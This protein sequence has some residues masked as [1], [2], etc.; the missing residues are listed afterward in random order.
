[1]HNFEF[2]V[3]KWFHIYFNGFLQIELYLGT[4]TCIEIFQT[5]V[6]FYFNLKLKF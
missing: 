1:M 5:L 2:G 3:F 6:Y 4:C